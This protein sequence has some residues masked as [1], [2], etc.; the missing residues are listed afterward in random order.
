M[1]KVAGRMIAAS[2]VNGGPSFPYL[3][4][5]VYKYL[6]SKSTENVLPDITRSDVVDYEVLQAIDKIDAATVDNIKEVYSE[7]QTLLAE[8]G[9]PQVL[10]VSNKLEAITA[11]CVHSVILSRKA[12]LDQFAVGLGPVLGVAM[13]YPDMMK[14]VFVSCSEPASVDQCYTSSI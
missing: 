10:S 2:I 1:F 8:A 6:T 12:E 9:F 11:L 13:K 7:V 3:S 5:A 4:P 14:S